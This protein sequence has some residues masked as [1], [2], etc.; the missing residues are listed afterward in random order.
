MEQSI[1]I[2]V[3]GVIFIFLG[4]G[5]FFW[6]KSEEKHYYRRILHRSDVREALVRR[7]KRPEPGALKTGGR[8]SMAV[9]AGLLVIGG[10]FWYWGLSI[11]ISAPLFR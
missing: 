5:I 1:I 6:G 9:G 10:A 7:P 8:V 3:L 2:L 11:F 4:I